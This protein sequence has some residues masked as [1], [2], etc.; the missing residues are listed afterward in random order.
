MLRITTATSERGTPRVVLAGSLSGPWIAELRDTVARLAPGHPSLEIDLSGV[1]FATAAAA[2]LLR[3]L[4]DR[5]V[6]FAGE[7]HLIAELMGVE[8]R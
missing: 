1:L 2:R 4:R 7:K 8:E 3:E 5:G 6:S